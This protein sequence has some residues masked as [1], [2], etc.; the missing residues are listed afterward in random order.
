MTSPP[1]RWT[2]TDEALAE[3]IEHVSSAPAY[4][5]DTEFHRERSYYPKVALV[6][7]AVPDL[8]ALVDPLAV[9]IA[10]LAK[11]LDSDVT[12][13]VHAAQQDLEVLSR[14]CG[15]VP[16]V[17]FDTQLA[18]G[19]V[20]YS[21][22]ALTNLVSSELGIRLPK[23]D[24]LTDWLARPLSDEQRAYAASDV[25]HLL[26]IRDRLVSKLE[27]AGRLE[28]A[29]DECEELR[30]RPIGPPDPRRAWLRIKDHRH[31]RGASR[32][33]AQ[34]VAAWRERRAAAL[35]QPVRFVLADL[36]ILGIAQRPP[37]DVAGLRRVRGIDERALR[38]PVVD[39]LLDAIHKGTEL[40][41]TEITQA[42][43][44][45][46]PRDLRPAVTLVSA[47]VSQL[48]RD[49]H[50][51]TML[52]ATRNDLVE[53]LVGSPT[54]R[55]AH[56]WR[57]ELVGDQIRRLVDGEAALA[58]DGSGGLVLEP[59]VGHERPASERSDGEHDRLIG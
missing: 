9:D 7:L 13:V 55:L 2:A 46:I 53:L 54:A 5:I 4:A 57:A 52:L 29:L 18:S 56:G 42:D 21:S 36:A 58:F 59:R 15:T 41:P 26:A 1:V 39:E 12:E 28:W 3:V 17:L 20:G 43:T 11:L 33:V 40:D 6:Q 38:K 14:G 24:R 48:A 16:R 27:A 10:P 45:E 51:D 19:F 32:G 30:T 47:W 22:P 23:G 35:D 49:L 8:I 37:T 34:E 31:L 50:I 25:A 44:E